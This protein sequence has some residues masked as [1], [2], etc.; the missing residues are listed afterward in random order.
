MEK[1]PK[2]LKRMAAGHKP[3]AGTLSFRIILAIIVLIL[4]LNIYTVYS[5]GTYQN[6]IIDQTKTSMENLANLYA[7]EVEARTKTINTFIAEIE[8]SNAD[9]RDISNAEQWDYYYISAIGLQNVLD[10]HM[11]LYRDGDM[12]FFYSGRME[13]GLLVESS[14]DLTK[15]EMSEALFSEDAFIKGARW[16]IISIGDTK[17][18]VHVN[19]RRGVYIG[20]GIQLDTIERNI[21]ANMENDTIHVEIDAVPEL[22]AGEEYISVTRKCDTQNL[23]F[24]LQVLRSEVIRSLPLLER[25]RVMIAAATL[26]IIPVM[27]L[28]LRYLV[29]RPISVVNTALNRIKTDPE[30]RINGRAPTEDFG[31]LYE[32]FNSMADEIVEL[33]IHNYEQQL[34]RQKVEFRNLQLQIKPHFLFNSL[35]LMYNLIQMKEYK[36]MQTMLLYLTDYFRYVGEDDSGYSRFGDE[37]DLIEKYFEVAAIRYE[38]MFETDCQIEDEVLDVM[39]PR[40]LIHNFV[41]NV[42]KHGLDLTRKTHIWLRAYIVGGKAV[43]QIRDDGT[44]M[45]K[46]QA[47]KI[48]RGIFEYEDGRKHVGLK[49]SFRRL[50]SYYGD[51]AALRIQSEKGEGTLVTVIIPAKQEEEKGRT[52]DETADRK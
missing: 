43:F 6:I 15:D 48:S 20:A 17:W 45:P 33:K 29:L 32:S 18:L 35:N 25:I 9:F 36:S 24:H 49:N 52:E 51:K 5:A 44:G 10:E 42:I 4:P 47:E 11:T 38:G 23:Y 22:S 7:G 46:K 14:A 34:E 19:L 39:V 2:N 3:A 40:L 1:C 16:Q 41:E 37:F 13:H 31:H 12:F 50:K 30:A 26:L 8:E 21:E 27:I 28:I